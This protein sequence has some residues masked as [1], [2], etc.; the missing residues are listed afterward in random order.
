M[1][2]SSLSMGSHFFPIP[3]TFFCLIL[4]KRLSSSLLV[5]ELE[6]LEELP[7]LSE[8]D[9]DVPL[10]DDDELDLLRFFFG[11]VWPGGRPRLAPPGA[12]GLPDFFF[13]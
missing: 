3:S 12:A 9:D 11:A 6:E 1:N 5:L 7:S 10:L 2:G 8:L 13:F 4:N